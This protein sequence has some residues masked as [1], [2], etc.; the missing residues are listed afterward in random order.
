[1]CGIIGMVSNSAVTPGMVL[2]LYDLQHRGEQGLGLV[3]VDDTDFHV[4]KSEGL[5]TEV[6]NDRDREGLFKDLPGRFGIGHTLYSTVGKAGESKQT[7]TFQPLQGNWQG[8]PFALSHNGNLIRLDELR[9]EAEEQGYRFQ[10]AVSDTEVIVGLLSVS[11]E[12]D[13][14][15]ALLKTLPRLEGAFS[16]A[17]LFKDKVIGVRDGLGVRPLC[18][19]RDENSFIFASEESAFHTLGANFVREIQPGELVVLSKN[20][21]EQSLIWAQNPH[22]RF[23]IF[24]YIYFA[25]IDSRLVSRRVNS[26]RYEAG[27]AVAEEHP[28]DADIVCSVPESGEVYNYGVASRLGIPVRRAISRNRYFARR[29]FMLPRETNRKN[30]QR[31]KFWILREVVHG[32]RVVATEDSILRANVSPEVVA[33]LREAGAS[34]VHLRVGS[35]PIRWP[36]FLGVDIP[37]RVELAAAGLSEEEVGTKIVRADSLGYLS[38]ER[39]IGATGLPRENLCLGCF[40]GEYPVDPPNNSNSKP[41]SS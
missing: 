28:V 27:E 13:F 11:R 10:S 39:M 5:V 9:R 3:T 16:L 37:T 30:L 4:H 8:Q 19:G 15:A 33:M 40:T 20:G 18:L 6:F 24:E 35:A 12:K 1:M 21:L 32:R 25:R 2:G 36:C 7:K 29:T 23:C 22:L 14:L 31:T 38:M 17:I 41:P 26:Y 34:E